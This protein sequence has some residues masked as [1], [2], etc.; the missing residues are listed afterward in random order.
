MSDPA[1]YNDHR[2]AAKVGR[3]LKELEA[4][5]KLAQEWREVRDDLDAARGDGDLRELVPEL[6][7]RIDRARGGAEARARRVR[8]RRREGRPR[9]GSPGGGRRRGR[10][11]GGRHL[12]DAG[13]LRGAAR[14]QDRGPLVEPERRRRVQGDHLRRQGRRRV[15]GLQVGGR[16]A[17]RPARP[18]DRVPGPHPHL[19]GDGR[20]HARGRGGRGRDRPERPEDRRL[21]LHRPR[22]PEREHDRLG[23]PDHAPSDRPR[24]RDAGREVAAPEQGEGDARPPRAPLRGGARASSARSR[25]RPRRSQIGSRRARREDP[26]VQ[27]RREPRHRP[28]D[29]ADPAPAR[30]DPRGRPRRVHRGAGRRGPAPRA[31]RGDRPR[32]AASTR[33]GAR[34]RGS[35]APRVDAELLLAHALGVSRSSCYTNGDE[36]LGR[37]GARRLPRARRAPGAPRA[38]RVRPRRVGLPAA[39]A[40]VDPRVLIPRPETEVLVERCLELLGG[41]REPRCST[42]APARARSR[43]R[44]PTSIP[45]P[46]GRDR[47]S[48]RRAGRRARERRARPGSRRRARRGRLLGGPRRARSTSSSRTRRTW[49]RTRSTRCS[50]RSREWEPRAALVGV[51]RDRGDRRGGAEPSRRRAARSC[52]RSPTARRGAVAELLEGSATRTSRSADDL[53]GRERV[54]D[55]RAPVEEAVE[56]IARRAGRSSCRPTR[57]TG[58]ACSARRGAA[59][60]LYALKGSARPSSRSRCS[61]RASTS[62]LELVPELAADAT[63]AARCCPARYTLDPPEPG[64]PLPAGCRVAAGHDRRARPELPRRL[65]ARRSTRVGAV[66][67]TSANLHGGPDPRRLDEVPEEIRP[68]RGRRRRRRAARASPST[69]VDLTGAEPRSCARAPCPRPRRSRRLGLACV[70]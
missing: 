3:R 44:S 30:P 35:A 16:H 12:P 58:S 15:L 22:R 9:R 31:R 23:R 55:G 68:A 26:H 48:R 61:P 6:E 24:R 63:I 40:A 57:S 32:P 20:G 11:L 19:H 66:A 67:A 64:A 43:W 2:E 14:L 42:S 18:A 54:V 49:R 46:G 65:A 39:D 10:A 59:Q 47:Q 69:V 21:P 29:Q 60:S 36:A 27:L 50:P 52:S 62:L 7:E 13:P 17:P 45:G 41:S 33:P 8:P 51:G 38:A 1:V 5:H 70:T 53:A 4:A 37:E 28:P 56:A 34:A 25:T